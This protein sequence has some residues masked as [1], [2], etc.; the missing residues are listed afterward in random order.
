MATFDQDSLFDDDTGCSDCANCPLKGRKQY[1]CKTRKGSILLIGDRPLDGDLDAE[2]A[3]QG[4]GWDGLFNQIDYLGYPAQDVSTAYAI[5]CT[6]AF[7]EKDG[8]RAALSCHNRIMD[9]VRESGAKVIVP[10]GRLAILA[11]IGPRFIGRISKAGPDSLIGYQIPDQELGRWVCSTYAYSDTLNDKAVQERKRFSEHLGAAMKLVTA[12]FPVHNFETE[13]ITKIPHAIEAIQQV[14]AEGVPLTFDYETTGLKPYRTGHRIVCASMTLNN[15][16]I[17]FPFAEF[18]SIEPK[19]LQAWSSLMASTK[20]RKIAH[21][22]QFEQEWT[23]VRGGGVIIPADAWNWDTQ[24]AAHCLDNTAPTGLKWQVYAKAGLLGWDD[25]VDQ[26]ITTARGDEDRLFG[27]NAFNCIDDCP[28]EDLLQYNAV[29]SAV[30]HYLYKQQRKEMR[31]APESLQYPG[32]SI[33]DGFALFMQASPEL[34]N[35]TTT[36]MLINVPYLRKAV[37]VQGKKVTHFDHVIEDAKETM[38]FRA[39]F[40]QAFNPAQDEHVRKMLYS[41]LDLPKTRKGEAIDEY[42]M[43]AAGHPLA[44]TILARRKASKLHSTYLVGFAREMTD[45]LIHPNFNLSNVVTFRSSSSNPNFQNLPKRDKATMKIIRSAVIA[46]PGRILKEY[47]YKGIEVS[48]SACVTKDPKLIE[49]VS[50]PTT[51]M[52]RDIFMDTFMCS[53]PEVRKPWRSAIKGWVTFPTFY[54]SIPEQM[55]PVI[56]EEMDDDLRDLCA[57]GGR[58]L[59]SEAA[60]LK[61]LKDAHELFWDVRFPVYKQWKFDQLKFYKKHGYVDQVSGFRCRGSMGFNDLGNYPIQ[62]P[63]FHGLLW[64][65]TNVMPVIRKLPEPPLALGQIHDALVLDMYP[66]QEAIVDATMEEYGC[67]RMRKKFPWVTV[68]LTVESEVSAIDGNWAEMHESTTLRSTL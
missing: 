30:A 67:N 19:F 26:Y 64:T 8:D 32:T 6:G 3:L 47:D 41:V 12:D 61:H 49:Y 4:S 13:I 24:L 29:D 9:T 52:H 44:D 57:S 45:G 20:A 14:E 46:R 62:G 40:G 51:D 39:Q 7:G 23:R 21:N 25:K 66:E 15:K 43:R 28:M 55:A 10:M 22:M 37:E 5:P 53:A 42:G 27:A 31:N 59:T 34:S 68:P 65:A 60:L 33:R 50:D 35:M 11:L 17:A 18:A 2:L 58:G 63:A 48:F 1:T 56:W 38:D 36:G 16:G 54:G